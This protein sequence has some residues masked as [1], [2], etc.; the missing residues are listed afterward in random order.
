M[1]LISSISS[2]FHTQLQRLLRGKTLNLSR[3][4]L[5]N[6]KK[7]FPLAKFGCQHTFPFLLL[8]NSCRICTE[9]KDT[10]PYFIFM[11]LLHNFFCKEDY[12]NL[13]S[14]IILISFFF[15]IRQLTIQPNDST[16]FKFLTSLFPG[17]RC[18]LKSSTATI[19]ISGPSH[20]HQKSYNPLP[21]TKCHPQK[22]SKKFIIHLLSTY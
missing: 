11:V 20:Q 1:T 4:Q 10:S 13:K 9:N 12:K 14:V 16:G 5:S 8:Q 22:L 15:L 19:K 17:K 18:Y 7:R 21:L 6:I 3:N 2:D